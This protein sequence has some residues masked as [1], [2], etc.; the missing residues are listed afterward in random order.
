MTE[1]EHI[2]IHLIEELQ[3][4]GQIATKIIRFGPKSYHPDDKNKVINIHLL[5]Q[6]LGNLYYIIDKLDELGYIDGVGISE[7]I[8]QKEKNMKRFN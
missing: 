6:E 1:E 3:E 4:V 5:S 2:L 8:E 7:G